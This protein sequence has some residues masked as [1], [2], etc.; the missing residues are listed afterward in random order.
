MNSNYIWLI[1]ST[2]LVFLMQPGFMCLE[3]GLTRTKNSINVAIKNLIDLGISILLFWAIGY[4]IVFGHSLFGIVGSDYF[5]FN[6]VDISPRK[7]IFFIFQMMFCSTAATIVSGATAERMKFTAYII[8]TILISGAIYPVFAHWTWNSYGMSDSVGFLERLGFVDFAGSTV[9]HSVGGW[10]SLAAVLVLGARTGR[11]DS[12]GKSRQIYGSN[13]PFAVLGVMLIWIGWLGFNGGSA[14]VLTTAVATIILNTMLAGAAGMISAGLLGWQRWRTVRV[15]AL[16][17]GSLA[18][19]VSI[20][21]VCNAVEPVVAIAI[22][23]V[24]G[25]FSI[26]VSYWLGCWQID[27]AVDAI[28]VH[29]GGGIWGTLAVALFGNP[30]ILDT[31]LNRVEQF[32][33]QLLGI[34]VCGLWAF[35]VTWIVLKVIDRQTPLRV[36][37]ADE[38]QGLN[39]SEHQAKSAV[40]E[41]L[42]VMNLQAATQDLSLRVPVEPFTEM[43]Y[44]AERYNR[45]IDSLETSTQQLKQL[46]DDLEQKVQ[47][48]TA[49]L[50]T[51]KEKAEVANRAKSSFVA[52]MSHELRTPLNAILGFTQ[53]MIRSPNLPVR[54]QKHLNIISSSGEHLLSLI[55]SVLE[56]SKIESEHLVLEPVSFDIY[57]FLDDLRQMFILKTES[58]SLQLKSL[59]SPTVPQ[60]IETDRNKLRQVL[61]NLLNNALKFTDRGEVVLRVTPASDISGEPD[62][63]FELIF[64]VEDTGK[65]IAPAELDKLFKPFSQTQTGREAKEGTG[66][67]LTISRRFVQF[68]GGDIEVQSVEDRGSVF[69]FNLPVR[70]TTADR[71]PVEE[72]RQ[73]LIL[74]PDRSECRVL[75]VDDDDSNRELLVELLEPIGFKIETSANSQEAI[76]L[77]QKWQPELILTD[78]RM[79]DCQSHIAIETIKSNPTSNTK[80]IALS[81]SVLEE[82]KVDILA[83]GYDDFLSKPFKVNE[84]FSIMAKHL[85]LCYTCEAMPSKR[86]SASEN[87][88]S[89]PDLMFTLD[90][91]S[92]TNISEDLLLELQRSILEINLDKIEQ[93][94]RQIAQHNQQLAE[95]IDGHISNF[96]YEYILN[97]LPSN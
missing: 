87:T 1:F 70:L 16:I 60:Y 37:L 40:Y 28:P 11:F 65:G 92:F 25:A 59:V 46:N 49:E 19:L 79:P 45:T 34:V 14:I 69:K 95:A 41:I 55:N 48:R 43:G 44:I 88:P 9:V 71:V 32:F 8:I 2:F 15:E 6:P 86:A 58:K 67:G 13:Q 3:S 12:A 83:M 91:N 94:V 47:Q 56:L 51:A 10:V 5:L 38:E 20:T 50:V 23:F 89:T 72:Q 66:L 53:L 39:I 74:E 76:A 81:G 57:R 84:L 29:L 77:W 26:L 21:A 17:N 31:G 27:D 61:I 36:S 80:V 85:E 18:G 97:L 54:Q 63:D 33:V 93:I 62:P 68:M 64:S 42:R 82:E 78:I 30:E 22:G 52:N 90:N 24:G 73:L 75:V 7:I 4:G 35:G 96:E